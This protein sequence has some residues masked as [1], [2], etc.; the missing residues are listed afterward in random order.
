MRPLDW[1]VTPL[2]RYADFGGRSTRTELCFFYL[3]TT[4]IG[5]VL[6]AISMLAGGSG[7]RAWVN[8]AYALVLICPWIALG[9][10]RLHD[11]GRSGW[12][13]LL[14]LPALPFAIW[15]SVRRWND[16]FLP[17]IQSS[18]PNLIA[19]PLALAALALWVLLFWNDQEDANRYGPNPR[20]GE[21]EAAA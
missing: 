7:I 9:A 11:T 15:D 13:L 20:Y 1:A 14:A 21:R 19:M 4:L 18:L 3:F 5:L 17:S 16:P 6:D 12:W 8:S 2:R 10:R